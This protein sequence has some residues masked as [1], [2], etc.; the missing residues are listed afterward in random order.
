M[1]FFG[2]KLESFEFRK[3]GKD[4]EERVILNAGGSRPS[5]FIFYIEE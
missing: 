5:C 4:D 3:N 2:E 1:R